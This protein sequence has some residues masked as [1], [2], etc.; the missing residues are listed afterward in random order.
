MSSPSEQYTFDPAVVAQ[1]GGKQDIEGFRTQ[2]RD[3]LGDEGKISP[4][5]FG[6]EQQSAAGRA[7]ELRSKYIERTIKKEEN[8]RKENA[9]KI[10]QALQLLGASPFQAELGAMKDFALR[11]ALS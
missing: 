4:Y 2:M 7:R 5:S 9:N 3:L 10:G 11:E 6:A 8:K 1:A